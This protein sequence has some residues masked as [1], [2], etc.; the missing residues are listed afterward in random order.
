[1]PT[2]PAILAQLQTLWGEPVTETTA[3]AEAESAFVPSEWQPSP[4]PPTRLADS[5]ATW[6]ASTKE[7]IGWFRANR[8]RLPVELF[9]LWPGAWVVDAAKFYRS[10]DADIASGPDGPRGRYGGLAHDLK[11]LRAV[12]RD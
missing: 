7:L 1:M 12:F 8:D 6:D 4:I 10:L 2:D 11:C 3:E 5:P 9:C